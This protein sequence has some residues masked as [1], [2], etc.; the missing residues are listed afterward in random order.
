MSSRTFSKIAK[1]KILPVDWMQLS[2]YKTPAF[3]TTL[4]AIPEVTG[5]PHMPSACPLGALVMHSP[6]YSRMLKRVSVLVLQ[7]SSSNHSRWAQASRRCLAKC[8]VPEWFARV[9]VM[10]WK[11]K[12]TWTLSL[13]GHFAFCPPEWNWIHISVAMWNPRGSLL[14]A[15]FKRCFNSFASSVHCTENRTHYAFFFMQS[16]DVLPQTHPNAPLPSAFWWN[17]LW[18]FTLLH[19]VM[20]L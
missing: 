5:C 18:S 9:Q 12:S 10:C 7:K 20:T 16:C 4:K 19:L 1:R 6:I 3:L 15:H 8:Q 2:H 11:N 14:L 17:I 13:L